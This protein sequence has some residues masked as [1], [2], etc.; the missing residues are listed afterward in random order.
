MDEGAYFHD[1]TARADLADADRLRVTNE[2]QVRVADELFAAEAV[3]E[4]E[5]M[6]KWIDQARGE[7]LSSRFREL[8][9]AHP[10]LIDQY[11]E[12]GRIHGLGQES[13]VEHIKDV[14]HQF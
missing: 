9:A 12:A 7:S 1:D 6:F 13:I 5:V 3:N 2:L 10:E 11:V 8:I 14:L 4:N